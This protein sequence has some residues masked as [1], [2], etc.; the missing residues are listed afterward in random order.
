MSDYRGYCQPIQD[1]GNCG[2]C[3]AYGSCGITELRGHLKYGALAKLSETDLFACSGGTCA[4]GNTVEAT[5]NRAMRGVPLYDC[6]PSVDHDTDC[7]D[8]RCPDWWIN[9]IKIVSPR[10]LATDAEINAAIDAGGVVA[11]MAVPESFTHYT[12]GHYTGQLGPH[13]PVLGYHMI[14][15]VGRDDD[16]FD[17]LRNSWNVDWGE[18]GYCWIQRGVCELEY[19]VFD[20]SDDVEPEE[21]Q[22]EPEPVN[23]G[24]IALLA[25]IVIA[26][27]LGLLVVYQ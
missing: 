19:Y 10:Q 4:R 13:D 9:A 21:P 15:I 24:L 1:Q 2:S 12:G 3:T 26:V 22:P 11:T 17:L 7:G 23:W 5:F 18:D 20:V 14:G 16:G 6:R 27:L 8:G 25:I